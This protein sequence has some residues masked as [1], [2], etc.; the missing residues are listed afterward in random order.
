[1]VPSLLKP[2]SLSL[3][4]LSTSWMWSKQ[5]S[6]LDREIM[7]VIIFVYIIYNMQH[8]VALHKDYKRCCSV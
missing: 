2:V 5:M 3:Q 4:E 7:H 1:M 8:I 6:G